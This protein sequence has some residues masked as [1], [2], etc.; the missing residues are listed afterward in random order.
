MSRRRLEEGMADL[1]EAP[2]NASCGAVAGR[3][4]RVVAGFFSLFGMRTS[5]L[6]FRRESRPPLQ[7]LGELPNGGV[8][9]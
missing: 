6:V 1:Q 4:A 3:G 7:V 5:S 2:K 9:C 8:V